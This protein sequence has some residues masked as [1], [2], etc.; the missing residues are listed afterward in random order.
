VVTRL[1]LQSLPGVHY[2]R[3]DT[4]HGHPAFAA[5]ADRAALFTLIEGVRAVYEAR[6]HGVAVT[7]SRLT[8]LVQ[9]GEANDDDARLRRRWALLGG[10]SEPPPARLRARLGSLSGFMQTLLQRASRDWNRRHGSRGHLWAGRYRATLLADD[11]ALL[12]AQTC[13]E[14]A[15]V[16]EIPAGTP[17]PAVRSLGAPVLSLAGPVLRLAANGF[18]F[19]A[20]EAP[21]ACAPPPADTAAEHLARFLATVPAASRAVYAHALDHGWALGRPESLRAVLAR[22]ARSGAGGGRGRILRDLDDEWGLCGV[23]G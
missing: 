4:A 18:V 7:P 3:V 17:V 13:L 12:A 1:S 19:P 10:R 16:A 6:L 8:L 11:R 23:W 2:V 5:G 14:D 9:P 20:D 15:L 22:L 21:P